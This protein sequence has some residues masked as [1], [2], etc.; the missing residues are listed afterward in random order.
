MPD[1]PIE[2]FEPISGRANQVFVT[3]TDVSFRR[4]DKGARYAYGE[5]GSDLIQALH[6]QLVRPKR[7]G[8][9][10]L[11]LGCPGCERPLDDVAIGEVTVATDIDLRKIPSI[12]LDLTMPGVVCPGCDRRLVMMHDNNIQSDLSDALIDAFDQAGLKPG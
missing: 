7:R 4:T 1:V 8:L 5:F 11:K 6:D 2:Q 12:H 9:L 3:L 10:R